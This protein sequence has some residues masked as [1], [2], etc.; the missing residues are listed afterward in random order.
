[1]SLFKTL[2]EL[3]KTTVQLAKE[4]KQFRKEVV[5]AGAT[6]PIAVGK[7]AFDLLD[8]ATEATKNI[9]KVVTKVTIRQV[10]N[11]FKAQGFDVIV[12]TE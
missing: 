9:E 12:D 1:M 3:A 4:D 2:T 8:N 6:Y 5:I 7:Y 10:E 11:K